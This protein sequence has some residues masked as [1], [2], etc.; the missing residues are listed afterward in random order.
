LH[1]FV[2]EHRL[3]KVR[4]APSDVLLEEHT[5]V[6]PDH[7]VVLRENLGRLKRN[8][9][10]GPPD[11]VVEVLSPGNTA[12]DLLRKL[13]LYERAGVREY[14]VVDPEAERVEVY[15]REPS[16]EATGSTRFARPLVLST[17]RDDV[18]ETPLLP[19]SSVPLSEIF[20]RGPE[21][22]ED[23]EARE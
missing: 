9:C 12:H 18:L 19:G 14:W 23:D 16:P 1:G 15:R 13:P 21:A 3:G 11:L 22:E 5:V 20:D 6:Q 2:R 17:A 4:E 8:G 10:H 7:Y